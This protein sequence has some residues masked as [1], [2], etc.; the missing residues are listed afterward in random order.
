MIETKTGF[1]IK[2]E[3]SSFKGNE[4]A[5]IILENWNIYSNQWMRKNKFYVPYEN[6]EELADELRRL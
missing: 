6:V 4:Y 5:A 2:V 3:K 1:R